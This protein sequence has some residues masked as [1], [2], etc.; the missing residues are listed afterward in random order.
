[1]RFSSH[2]AMAVTLLYAIT[3]CEKSA[4]KSSRP[5]ATPTGAA[6]SQT[7][8]AEAGAPFHDLTFDAACQKA[9]KDG[10]VVM[11]DFYTTWCAPCK[12]LDK[13]TWHDEAVGKWLRAKTVALKIDAEKEKE[14]AA[15][16]QVNAYPTL[17]FLKPDGKEMDR[18][19]GFLEPQDFLK[20]AADVVAGVDRAQP[21]REELQRVG[22]DP[23]KRSEL[24]DKLA[25]LRK[26]SEALEQYLWC[27][28]HGNEYSQSYG[29][30]RLSFLLSHIAR[31]GQDYPPALTALR[32]RRD[33]A[34][35][36]VLSGGGTFK[37]A[38]EVGALNRALGEDERTLEVFD[39]ITGSDFAQ[40]DELRSAMFY[41][42]FDRLLEAKRY[43]DILDSVRG[44]DVDMA[45]DN[46]IDSYRRSVEQYKDADENYRMVIDLDRQRVIRDGGKFYEALLGVHKGEEASKLADRLIE[47]D[48]S[49]ETFGAL[50]AH[51]ERAG[52]LETARA[53]VKRGLE[54]LPEDQRDKVQSTIDVMRRT[55]LVNRYFALVSGDE[56]PEGGEALGAEVV[57]SLGTD[58][59][60]LNDF[61][62]RVLTDEKVKSRD[63]KLA[64]RVAKAAYDGCEGQDAMIV[65]TYALALW[66]TGSQQE[67]ITLQRKAIQLATERGNE[68]LLAELQQR[69]S[70][71]EQEAG[72]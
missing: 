65:D 36:V 18:L 68:G 67:A 7:A 11:V 27:F 34:M 25:R 6:S 46:Y 52:D 63:R 3:G 20:E 15:R 8:G 17:L 30:V 62:W 53:L 23:G 14:L 66:D 21:V 37:D 42:V 9:K 28:D 40:K 26:H 4:D 24:A 55:D 72:K 58:A 64:L 49:G 19:A 71:Y 31:L 54:T 13:Q 33:K 61:A 48:S 45:I 57:D 38:Q 5:A 1:M 35:E 51:A 44:G 59:M 50:A 47:F 22:N 12:M 56:R 2:A 69:L 43:H 39:R 70:R 60:V 32:E 41:S 16:Y 10:K 29:A